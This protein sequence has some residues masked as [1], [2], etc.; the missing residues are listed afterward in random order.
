MILE[1]NL[2]KSYLLLTF[3]LPCPIIKTDVNRCLR[4]RYVF[5]GMKP[6]FI[7]RR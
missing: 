3:D 5:R 6:A 7:T 2:K 1:K 4:M